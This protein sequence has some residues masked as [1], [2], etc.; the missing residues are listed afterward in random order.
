MYLVAMPLV[1]SAPGSQ[2][3]LKEG[4]TSSLVWCEVLVGFS[5]VVVS[6]SSCSFSQELKQAMV[7]RYDSPNAI[8][9]VVFESSMNVSGVVGNQVMVMAINS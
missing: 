3:W 6:C 1:P 2:S 9:A 7:D 4:P 5:L 8:L